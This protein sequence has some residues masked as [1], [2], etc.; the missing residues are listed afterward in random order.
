MQMVEG[1]SRLSEVRVMCLGLIVPSKGEKKWRDIC[2]T[3]SCCSVIG[4]DESV[5]QIAPKC[6]TEKGGGFLAPENTGT[7]FHS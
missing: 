2:R 7:V 6:R 3:D 4:C 5:I 1:A